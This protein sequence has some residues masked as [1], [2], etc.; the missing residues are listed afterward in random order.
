[1]KNNSISVNVSYVNGAAQTILDEDSPN[2]ALKKYFFPD[3]GMPVTLFIRAKSDD[4]KEISIV[5]DKDAIS[6]SDH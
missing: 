2:E 4:G 3:A 6:I 1:M 5:I